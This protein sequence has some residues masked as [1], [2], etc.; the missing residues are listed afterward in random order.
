MQHFDFNTCT[1][2]MCCHQTSQSEL[3]ASTV[4][5]TGKLKFKKWI[6]FNWRNFCFLFIL[7]MIKIKILLEN[8]QRRYSNNGMH[9][10]FVFALCFRKKYS[11]RFCLWHYTSDILLHCTENFLLQR[12]LKKKI[13]RMHFIRTV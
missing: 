7:G 8:V 11:Q 2:T 3:W 5:F 1:Q 10:D 4:L 9:F 13:Y 6:F 12:I